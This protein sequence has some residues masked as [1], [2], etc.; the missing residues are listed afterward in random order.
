[1]TTISEV[2]VVLGSPSLPLTFSPRRN[3]G[4]EAEP[5]VVAERVVLTLSPSASSEI[6]AGIVPVNVD[7]RSGSNVKARGADRPRSGPRRQTRGGKAQWVL[8]DPGLRW[9]CAVDQAKLA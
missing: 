2:G 1:M 9:I 5:S 6:D 8:F 7:L 4:D 3:R